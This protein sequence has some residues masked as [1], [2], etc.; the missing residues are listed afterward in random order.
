MALSALRLPSRKASRGVIV[1]RPEHLGFA[2]SLFFGHFKAGSLFPYPILPPARRQPWTKPSP[3]FGN[4]ANSRSI[5]PQS[6]GPRRFLNRSST[7][8]AVGVWA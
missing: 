4:S 1:L 8:S 5:Q 3:R 7:V 6:T 2:K